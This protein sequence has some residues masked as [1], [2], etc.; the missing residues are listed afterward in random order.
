MARMNRASPSTLTIAWLFLC[1]C[2][3][4]QSK[5]EKPIETTVC[6]IVKAPQQFEGKR[7]QVR[8]RLWSDFH[9]YWMNDAASLQIGKICPWL[10]AGF[11]YST[12]LLGTT[13]FGTFTG[14]IIHVPTRRMGRLRS[15]LRLVV[16]EQA[17]IYDARLL[18]GPIAKPQ[19]YDQDSGTF[20]QPQSCL[21]L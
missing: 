14:T 3:F 6:E 13:A 16:E 4:A 19:L 7:V 9:A 1:L 18:N 11:A 15:C 2:T 10:P 20:V 17:D 21:L 5:P 12:S 8:A